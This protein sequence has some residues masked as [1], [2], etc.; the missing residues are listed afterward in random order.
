M[1]ENPFTLFYMNRTRNLTTVLTRDFMI[2]VAD[3]IKNNSYL[4]GKIAY[5]ILGGVFGTLLIVMFLSTFL[6]IFE[7]VRFIP[8][9]IGLNTAITGYALM[10]KTRNLL[11]YKQIY[12]VCAGILNV[13]ITYLLLTLMSVH[14]LGEY[15]FG[16]WDLIVFLLI[17]IVCSELGAL[18][19]IKY[20][21]LKK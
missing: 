20:F 1:V 8:W 5:S 6:Y 7:L 13:I 18:L 14:I 2:G 11:K 17:G 4:P 19:A 16:I 12:S 3:F 9:I 10:D 15:L 21:G